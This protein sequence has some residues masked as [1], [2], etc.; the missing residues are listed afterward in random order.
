MPDTKKTYEHEPYSNAWENKASEIRRAFAPEI[1]PCQKCGFP[2][3]KG[4]CCTN[5]NDKN[6]SSK[7]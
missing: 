2:V 4:Y 3:A 6:P 1:Y 5:C 7:D